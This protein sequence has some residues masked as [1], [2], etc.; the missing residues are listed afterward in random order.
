MSI[1]HPKEYLK[2]FIIYLAWF[3]ATVSTFLPSSAYADLCLTD[4]SESEQFRYRTAYVVAGLTVIGL[5]AGIAC[6]ATASGHHKHHSHCSCSSLDNYRPYSSSCSYSPSHCHHSYSDCSCYYSDYSCYSSD[7]CHRHHHRHHH[8]SGFSDGSSYSRFSRNEYSDF[9]RGSGSNFFTARGKVK[10]HSKEENSLS[11]HFIVHHNR[12][13]NGTVTPF[14]QLPDGTTQSLG[15]L[16]LSGNGSIP[17]GPYHQKGNYTFGMTLDHAND[18]SSQLK[19]G[20][21][22][23]EMNG[24]TVQKH[25]FSVPAHSSKSYEPSPFCYQLD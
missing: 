16:P 1:T 15:T 8:H 10:P 12:E 3:C 18:S 24:S 5:A 7:S 23:V 13:Q 14:I 2:R 4:N 11:G 20:S 6:L 19:L 21:F 22:E 25:D 17:Y 9:D